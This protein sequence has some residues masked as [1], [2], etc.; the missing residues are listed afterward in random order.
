MKLRVYYV[1]DDQAERWS[2]RVPALHVAGG[3]NRSREEVEKH[4]MS[5]IQF[6][7]EAIDTEGEELRQGELT[8]Y[9]VQILVASR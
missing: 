3:G 9:E 8:E 4:C 2:F 7:L 1:Y 6:R 5:A